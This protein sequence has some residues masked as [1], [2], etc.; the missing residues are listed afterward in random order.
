MILVDCNITASDTYKVAAILDSNCTINHL[1]FSQNPLVE[2]VVSIVNS[3][4]GITIIEVLTLNT[5]KIPDIASSHFASLARRTALV[6]FD[7]R[8]NELKPY[9]AFSIAREFA[10]S[11]SLK[12]L[13]IRYWRGFLSEYLADIGDN[14]EV[15]LHSKGIRVLYS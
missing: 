7:I 1:D 11:T 4:M 2:D 6:E 5:C 8:N 13:K 10:D 12:V 3:L 15:L 9:G 14:T